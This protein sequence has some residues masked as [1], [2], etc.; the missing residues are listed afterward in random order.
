MAWNWKMLDN[1][2]EK[3]C[4]ELGDKWLLIGAEIPLDDLNAL[5]ARQSKC[6]P[7]MSAESRDPPK[8]DGP[9][10]HAVLPRYLALARKTSTTW[11]YFRRF[12]R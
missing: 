8:A 7:A 11:A 6:G 5:L 3:D 10:G 2:G 9:G 12:A 4:I 1:L